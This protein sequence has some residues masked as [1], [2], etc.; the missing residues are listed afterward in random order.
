MRMNSAVLQCRIIHSSVTQA[1]ARARARTRLAQYEEIK[2]K[3]KPEEKKKQATTSFFG[4][5]LTIQRTHFTS[6]HTRSMH[7]ATMAL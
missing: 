4:L 5:N 7:N 1:C 2:K 6:L 3:T